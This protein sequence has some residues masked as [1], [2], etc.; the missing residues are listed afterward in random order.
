[1]KINKTAQFISTCILLVFLFLLS[2]N[3]TRAQQ[4]FLADSF[5]GLSDVI[6]ANTL[7]ASESAHKISFTLPTN[8]NPIRKNDY[9]RMYFQHFSDV[10]APTHV[11]GDYAGFP[12]FSVSGKYSQLTGIRVQP[13]A[14]I[15][16]E[17]IQT[18]NPADEN[19]FQ[20]VVM[21]TED[22]N[23]NIIKNI[24]NTI[25]TIN[26]GSVNITASIEAE[27]STLVISGYTSPFAFLIFSESNS[28]LGTDTS[29]QSGSFVKYF[30]GLQPTT[31]NI[32]FYS[33]DQ[34]SFNTSP[35]PISIYTPAFL[36]TTISNQLL[37]P[38]VSIND[39]I[40]NQGDDFVAS[41]SAVP[42]GQITL[43]TDT[44]LRS[45][46]AS[47]AADGS[48]NY[49]IN[50]TSDYYLGDY[51]AYALVQTGGGL[52]SLTSPSLLFTITTASA[53]GTACGDI[54]QGD[55]N[56]DSEVNLQDFSILMYYWGTRDASADI[57]ADTIVNLNDFSIMMYYWGT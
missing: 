39:Y 32:T 14:Y 33:V 53:S 10:T 26:R 1:M 45:Y 16:I 24:G 28:V 27:L 20:V 25:A 7:A 17:G 48:W 23:F 51:R 13:G 47:A 9:I 5:F 2:A 21:V 57:N 55:L 8:S 19:D 18:T 3:K 40:I 6:S 36:E 4:D 30:S 38:T 12:L 46:I 35:Q 31:H 37:S 15:S 43:L 56:C 44:P 22:S 50:N 42:G 41:G 52:Q 49:T 11:F 54:S 29:N 34:F